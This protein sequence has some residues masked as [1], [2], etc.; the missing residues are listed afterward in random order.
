MHHLEISDPRGQNKVTIRQVYA[1]LSIPISMD[2]VVKLEDL[3]RWKHLRDLELPELSELAQVE[4]LIGQDCLEVII[5][6]EVRVSEKG[7]AEP[8]PFATRSLFGWTISGILGGTGRDS[9]ASVS[10]IS[11]TLD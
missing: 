5:P 7:E 10:F 9:V 4:M 6:L 8:A 3:G 11:K 2:S 1:T